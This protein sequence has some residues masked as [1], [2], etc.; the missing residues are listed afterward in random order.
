MKKSPDDAG[1]GAGRA[2]MIYEGVEPALVFHHHEA[3]DEHYGGEKPM[4]SGVKAGL[5]P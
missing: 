1:E 2:M 3:V 5:Q 4:P